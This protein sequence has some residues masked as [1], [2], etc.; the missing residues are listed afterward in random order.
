[1]KIFGIPVKIDPTFL[2][3]CVFL[4]AGRLSQPAYL[5]EW[6]IVVFVS[7]LIHELG[8]A[9]VVRSFG[10]S[11]HITIYMLGGLTSWRDEKSVSH[12]KHIAVSLAGPFAGFTFFGAVF[13]LN[14]N[15]PDLFG[16]GL[17]G[18]QIYHD[19]RAV[20]LW[21]GIFNLL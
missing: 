12:A 15:L 3:A 21:W 5:V 9:L 8:H 10:L 20:N 16:G 7:I 11:P 13:V 2:F 19:L 6:V 4:G 1:M 17:F 18:I 14:A